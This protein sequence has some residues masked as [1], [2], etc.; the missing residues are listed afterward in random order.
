MSSLLREMTVELSEVLV[1]LNKGVP[2]LAYDGMMALM[3]IQY[4]RTPFFTLNSHP[5]IDIF[6]IQLQLSLLALVVSCVSATPQSPATV[7]GVPQASNS[8]PQTV[9][10]DIPVVNTVYRPASPSF[11]RAVNTI[12]DRPIPVFGRPPSND[13]QNS[14]TLELLPPLQHVVGTR[15]PAVNPGPGYRFPLSQLLNPTPPPNIH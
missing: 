6:Q 15:Y 14:D 12:F 10:A 1:S 4:K 13:F 3:Y 5:R 2:P 7:Y 9:P 11:N 8:P